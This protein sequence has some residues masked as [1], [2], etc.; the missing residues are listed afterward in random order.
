M[1]VTFATRSFP[2]DLWFISYLIF[3]SSKCK[4]CYVK[5]G[6]EDAYLIKFDDEHRYMFLLVLPLHWLT[7]NVR[8]FMKFFFPFFFERIGVV[9]LGCYRSVHYRSIN[10]WC[11][12][13]GEFQWGLLG[14]SIKLCTGFCQTF[15]YC[16]L[17][18]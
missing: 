12:Q 13:F 18:S 4:K 14:I 5:I 16:F 15:C 17:S 1:S 2:C 6:I 7:E 9:A 10:Q 3:W 8:V 11:C